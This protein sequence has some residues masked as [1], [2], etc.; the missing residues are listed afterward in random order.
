MYSASLSKLDAATEHAVGS[1]PSWSGDRR[2]RERERGGVGWGESSYQSMSFFE[3]T[4]D[5]VIIKLQIF[6]HD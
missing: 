5:T 3:H 1:V 6:V 4:H 2:E